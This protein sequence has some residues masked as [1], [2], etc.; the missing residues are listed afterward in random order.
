MQKVK[1]YLKKNWYILANLIIYPLILFIP[2]YYQTIYVEHSLE[3][4][5]FVNF[6]QFFS[7]VNE[8]YATFSIFLIIGFIFYFFYLFIL[9]LKNTNFY[10]LYRYKKYTNK[11]L[12]FTSF[13][14][15]IISLI[16]L[17]ILIVFVSTKQITSDFFEHYYFINLGTPTL[18]IYSLIN[19]IITNL[20]IKGKNYEKLH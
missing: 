9:F 8:I 12:I 3:K 5:G 16:L 15:L 1:E 4:H 10:K 18:F 20:S 6:Y 7:F 19:F 14:L 17:I 13:C 11:L 2:L